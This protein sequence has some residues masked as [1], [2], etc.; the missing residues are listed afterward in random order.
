MINSELG[1]VKTLKQFHKEIVRQQTEAHGE[2][3]CDHHEVI[4]ERMKE[5]DSYMELGTHQGGTAS[6]ALLTKPKKI[7]LVDND[8]SRYRKFL[9]PIAEEFC[10]KHK[11]ILKEIE[12]D[13]TH[14]KS[15]GG[16]VDFLL[17][18]SYHHPQHMSREL[19]THQVNI[20]KY[21]L[22][23]DTS[24]INGRLNS[25]LYEALVRFCDQYPF[26]VIERN[27]V[28]EG[29]TLLERVS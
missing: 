18:D 3:Y 4:K 2:H 12:Q 21:I 23:H 8:M 10:L 5:C 26:K 7:V 25:S 22:A 20:K 1:H 28:A 27:E 19:M 24:I 9:Q 14:L 29:Y 6:A 16:P 13:S 11:I 17:I 15:S